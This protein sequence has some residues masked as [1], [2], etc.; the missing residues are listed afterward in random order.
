MTG[1]VS[2]EQRRIA[3]ELGIAAG[4][5]P[6]QEEQQRAAFLSEL[7]ASSSTRTLVRGFSGGID[8]A[9]MGMLCYRATRRST[10]AA[11]FIAVRLPY[12]TQLDDADARDA[13]TAIDAVEVLTVD[14]RPAADAALAAV[15]DAGL[16]FAS[17]AA[18]DFVL[19]NITARRCMVPAP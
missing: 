1:D 18:H 14:G 5:D 4:F 19:G 15:S 8:P 9:V 16:T 10:S 11:H 13:V 7:L 2:A 17:T 12:D 6:E 3:T